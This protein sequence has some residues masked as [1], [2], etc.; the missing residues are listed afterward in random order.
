[1]SLSTLS[2]S[3]EFIAYID[4]IYYEGYAQRMAT[5]NPAR[6]T[7]EYYEFLKNL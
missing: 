1:M 5:E 4:G 6:L 7:Y 3:T 2:R